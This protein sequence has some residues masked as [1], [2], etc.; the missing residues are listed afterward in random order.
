MELNDLVGKRVKL[1]LSEWEQDRDQLNVFSGTIEEIKEGFILPE[2][3]PVGAVV[4]FSHYRSSSYDTRYRYQR[5]YSGWYGVEEGTGWYEVEEGT[6]KHNHPWSY[7]VEKTYEM[8]G[9][10]NTE[11]FVKL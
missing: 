3:P 1:R 8:W 10:E 9:A 7:L 4:V 11:I 2:E 5:G 6:A